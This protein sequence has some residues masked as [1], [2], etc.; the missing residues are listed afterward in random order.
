MLRGLDEYLASAGR[1]A[2]LGGNGFYWVTGALPAVGEVI[3]VRRGLSGTRVWESEPGEEHHFF[4]GERGGLWRN[5][6]WA[7]QRLV[8]VGFTAQG[9]DRALPFEWL[10]DESHP[11]AGF[12]CRGINTSSPLDAPG[13]VLGGAAGFEIDRL[14]R[15]LG[16]PQGTVLVASAEGFSDAYQGTT[17]DILAADSRQGGTI[18]PL[19]RADMTFSALPSGGA[20]FSVGSISWCGALAGAVGNN[21]VARVTTNVIDRMSSPEPFK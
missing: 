3:E 5:R 14:D 6:G 15:A 1:L 13:S 2:Y 7:P 9:F 8:G 11:I 12:I 17:E 20:V 21:T 16:T 4:T 18:S 10:I 19:V